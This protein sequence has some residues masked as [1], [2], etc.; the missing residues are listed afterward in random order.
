MN[1]LDEEI[2]RCVK[3]IQDLMRSEKPN[4]DRVKIYLYQLSNSSFK[5][6]VHAGKSK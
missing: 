2:S 3:R 5:E 1:Y 4:W 6:G